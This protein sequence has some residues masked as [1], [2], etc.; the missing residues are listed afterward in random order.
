MTIQIKDGTGA[1]QYLATGG[2]DGSSGN[3]SVSPAATVLG[4]TAG[5]A[6]IT[7]TNG[8]VQQYLRGLV[9]L[10]IA[11]LA[12]NPVAGVSG[13]ANGNSYLPTGATNQ[14]STVVKNTGG[15]IYG[16]SIYNT[17]PAPIYLKIYDK[18]TPP[19]STDT[20]IQR[21]LVPANYTAANGFGLHLESA[22]GPTGLKT[23][24]GITFR[25]TAGMADNDTTAVASN[26]VIVNL[27]T[28]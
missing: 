18:A 12:S 8:T 15:T 25:V 11:G 3:P 20:P 1:T 22:I 19:I 17:S 14:D 9:K 28:F 4:T 26:T 24:N 2:G 21:Y 13:G 16:G 23:N 10:I 7:D 6:V 5:A 27:I